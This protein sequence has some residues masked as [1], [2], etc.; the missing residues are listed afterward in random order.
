MT[1]QMASYWR[2]HPRFEDCLRFFKPLIKRDIP[3]APSEM[4]FQMPYDYYVNGEFEMY[5]KV[6]KIER[7]NQAVK[8]TE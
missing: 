7:K 2:N 8:A 3:R 5:M 4:F 1:R 6:G